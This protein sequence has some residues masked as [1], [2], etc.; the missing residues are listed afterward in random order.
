MTPQ[1]SLLIHELEQV[2]TNLDPQWKQDDSLKEC[3]V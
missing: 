3:F 1:K 2:F